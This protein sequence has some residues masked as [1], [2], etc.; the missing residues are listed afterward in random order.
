M[1]Y[2][3][4][5][6]H[7]NQI[8]EVVCLPKLHMDAI[9]GLQSS[10]SSPDLARLPPPSTRT[11]NWPMRSLHAPHLVYISVT[12]KATNYWN[13]TGMLRC[14]CILNNSIFSKYWNLTGEH[15]STSI[16]DFILSGLQT[17]TLHIVYKYKLTTVCVSC[18]LMLTFVVRSCLRSADHMFPGPKCTQELRG[19]RSISIAAPKLWNTVQL[20]IRQTPFLKATF[21]PWLFKTT[22]I[23]L[24]LFV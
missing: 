6:T 17:T 11:V 16:P 23:L 20:D 24:L 22:L 9:A 19:E 8:P 5:C 21:S 13:D 2:F 12:W 15:G 3:L 4:T 18:C 7:G 14:M 1:E 10:Q